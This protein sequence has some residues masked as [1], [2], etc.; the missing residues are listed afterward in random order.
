MI[1]TPTQKRCVRRNLSLSV[2]LSPTSSPSSPLSLTTPSLSHPLSPSPLFSLFLSLSLSPPPSTFSPPP[3][4][5]LITRLAL[6]SIETVR[7]IRD[8]DMGG[9]GGGRERVS[10]STA[11]SHPERPRTTARTTTMLRQWGPCGT[12]VTSFE[13]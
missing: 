8:R 2:C 1:Q 9:G 10:D 4:R 11:H 12:C 6:T 13:H 3:P 7:L 5:S